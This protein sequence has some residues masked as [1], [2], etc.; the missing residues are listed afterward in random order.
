MVDSETSKSSK[1]LKKIPV[2]HL[3]VL[4][5]VKDDY[6]LF[7]NDL[8]NL[9]KSKGN[10]YLVRRVYHI[11]QGDLPN[12]SSKYKKFIEKHRHTIEIMNKYSC[13]SNLTV[14]SYDEKGKH[15]N[16][17]P[18]DYF[19]EY[20]QEHKEDIETIKAVTLKIKS[21]G[22]EEINFDENLD[23]TKNEYELRDS[24]RSSFVFLENMEA[25]PTYLESPVK[26]RTNGSCY[27]MTLIPSSYGYCQKINIFGRRIGLNNLI[28]D[29]N[30]LPEEITPESTIEVIKKL[31][32][33]KKTEHNDLQ[34][35]VDLSIT[36]SD[37]AD[38]YR[39]LKEVSEKIIRINNNPELTNILSQIQ[40]ALQQLESFRASF[41]EQTINSHPDITDETIQKEK[42]LYL[43]R[44]DWNSIDLD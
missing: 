42:K 39:K 33:K 8:E 28:F 44:R 40:N 14:L 37:L 35:V 24:F 41:E 13:L 10:R 9:I 18:E 1:N 12:Y 43:D 4:C 27:C 23:F 34:N 20:I 2:N 6:Q 29:P 25:I 7:C 11:I 19:Y 15:R 17:L 3:L 16:N 38:Y 26:Y 36:T 31:A 30:R 22:F 32:Q 21:L 5:E